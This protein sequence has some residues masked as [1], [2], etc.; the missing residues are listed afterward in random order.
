MNLPNILTISRFFLIP[1][2]V[3][4]F[5]QGHE[6]IAFSVFL[7]AGVTDVIDGYLARRFQLVTELGKMLDP[8]ADKL[9]VLSVFVS[10]LIAG[11]ISWLVAGVVFFRDAGMIL[12]S[13]FF[14]FRG[15]KTV[16]AN[17]LGKTT[18][19]LFYI[20]ILL[21]IFQLPYHTQFIWF[22]VMFAFLTSI[23][24]LL[25]FAKVNKNTNKKKANM[26]EKLNKGSNNVDEYTKGATASGE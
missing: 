25:E 20:A 9:M 7:L 8:L 11:K 22:V 10:L 12:G 2:F 23:I 19:I 17:I 15:K 3:V 18:T 21:L 4:L 6:I 26:K 1:V 5:F 14:H 13:L 16:P 24:Y